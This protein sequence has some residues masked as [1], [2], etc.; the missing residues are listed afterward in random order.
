ML[1]LLSEWEQHP[2]LTHIGLARSR[3]AKPI[4]FTVVEWQL[5]VN[6]FRLSQFE[7]HV[8][9]WRLQNECVL[10]YERRGSIVTYRVAH[11]VVK[12]ILREGDG[13]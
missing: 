5:L 9:L 1:A 4:V 7:A 8:A 3:T 11:S 10:Q 2:T 13:A 12:E 6:A